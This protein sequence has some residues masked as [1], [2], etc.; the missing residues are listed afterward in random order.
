MRKSCGGTPQKPCVGPQAAGGSAGAAGSTTV[1]LIRSI[2]SQSGSR[3]RE[4][5]RGRVSSS[6]SGKRD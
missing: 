3:E 6:S 2:F 5:T 4:M 1:A